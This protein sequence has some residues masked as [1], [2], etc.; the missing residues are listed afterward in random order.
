M[1]PHNDFYN[2]IFKLETVFI[3]IFP[4]I[5]TETNVGEKIK[6]NIINIPYSHPCDLFDNQ[7]LIYLFVRFRIYTAIKIL[8]RHMISEK[9]IK[10]RKLNVPQHL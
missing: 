2:Y 9:K 6:F 7:Y 8:N 5:S 1:M 4:T 3:N 10:N